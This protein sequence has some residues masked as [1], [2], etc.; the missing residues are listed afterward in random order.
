MQTHS[1]HCFESKTT[2]LTEQR[3]FKKSIQ[4]LVQF[5]S[6]AWELRYFKKSGGKCANIKRKY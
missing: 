6:V 4:L 3:S 5:K 1:R 2:V